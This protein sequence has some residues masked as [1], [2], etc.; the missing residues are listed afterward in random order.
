MSN[1][2][3]ATKRFINKDEFNDNELLTMS[4]GAL[5]QTIENTMVDTLMLVLDKGEEAWLEFGQ[6]IKQQYEDSFNHGD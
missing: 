2:I 3:D 5:H 4:Y 1:V 6:I